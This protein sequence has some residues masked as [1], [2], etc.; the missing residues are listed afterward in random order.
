[1]DGSSTSDVEQLCEFLR[2]V[3]HVLIRLTPAGIMERLLVDFRSNGQTGPGVHLLPEV[4][5]LAERL[6]TIAEARPDFPPPERIHVSTWPLR[7]GALERLGVV[8][9]IRDRLAA[10]DA[11][12]ALQQLDD[13][14]E[15]L[16]RLEREEQVRAITG[17][18]YR[19]LW[20]PVRQ[21]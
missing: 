1:M 7:I 12:D 4:S 11:F 10:M 5:S 2:T 14:Y 21:A 13:S 17:E 15:R 16:L 9:A 6:R 8:A 3:D 20:P 18:G 19:T